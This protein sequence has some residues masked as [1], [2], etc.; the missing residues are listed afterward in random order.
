MLCRFTM[1]F[2][3]ATS[4]KRRQYRHCCISTNS[5]HERPGKYDGS[6]VCLAYSLLLALDLHAW[7]FLG[8]TIGLFYACRSV[9]SLP[10]VWRQRLWV[11]KIVIGKL[12]KASTGESISLCWLV[13][14]RSSATCIGERC[15]ERRCTNRILWLLLSMRHTACLNGKLAQCI[16]SILEKRA[17]RLVLGIRIYITCFCILVRQGCILQERVF[18][19]RGSAQLDPT[20]CPHD[21]TYCNSYCLNPE[22]SYHYSRNGRPIYSSNITSQAEHCILG[23]RNE[24]TG[25]YFCPIDW[26]IT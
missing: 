17:F 3:W 16:L 23:L 1:D 5:S 24:T 14:N 25:S 12:S 6:L 22:Q 18:K 15:Y 4:A 26:W 11:L 21:C 7:I 2:R 10:G 20:A 8:I 19:I 13:Q 9:P